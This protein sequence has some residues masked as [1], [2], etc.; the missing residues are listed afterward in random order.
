MTS[1]SPE[2]RAR[3]FDA[4]ASEYDR[5][6][7]GYPDELFDRI[8]NRFALADDVRAVDLGSG[9]GKVARHVALRGWR[10][11]AVEPGA[12][13]R[14]VLAEAAHR[15]R[16]AVEVVDGT[17][18][19]TGLRS[20]SYDLSLAGEAWH[21]FDAARALA[22]TARIVRTGGGLAFFW[23]V[24]E[25]ARCDLAAI[26]HALARRLGIDDTDIRLPGPRPETREALR[27]APGWGEPEFSQV[28]HVV[29]MTGASYLG[30]AQ[31]KSHFRAADAEVQARFAEEFRTL[32]AAQGIG[33]TDVVEVPF[34]IDCWMTERSDR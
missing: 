22:E 30:W 8:A 5:Y 32:S 26:E 1:E 31:T 23:N 4:W 29:R 18:E 34:T 16:V 13:M 9:T 25:E 20:A 21:W 10:V 15:E 11:T 19:A 2:I 12:G 27:A 33:L 14:A 24:V 17:A 6:R 3:S 28:P 7:P